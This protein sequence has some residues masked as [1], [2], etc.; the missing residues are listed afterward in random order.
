MRRSTNPSPVAAEIL[1][2][3]DGEGTA[4]TPRVLDR[5]F[6]D[7][8]DAE[9]SEA[10]AVVIRSVHPEV[11]CSGLDL[12][13]PD[14]GAERGVEIAATFF[15]L[16]AELTASR[17]L[18]V[19][20]VDGWVSGG[21]VGLV[22]AADLVL[23][24]ERS[25]FSLPELIWGLLPATVLPFVVRRC[26]AQAARRLML[27]TTPVTAERAER[28]GL[29]DEVVDSL[30]PA[31][32]ALTAR[33]G[34]LDAHLLDEAKQYAQR[35]QSISDDDRQAAVERLRSLSTLVSEW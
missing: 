26:G 16:M 24:T 33:A 4:L 8:A 27:T 23:A 1:L 3:R 9:D 17:L 21:G 5:I 14:I 6:D 20:A 30:T 28:L 2:G 31:I 15:D 10:V 11:Y 34:R 7:L 25:R 22:C 18:V 35:W 19:A 29:V 13:Q 32:E 12:D